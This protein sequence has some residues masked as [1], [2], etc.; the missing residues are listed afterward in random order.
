MLKQK[1]Y[2]DKYSK[3]VVQEIVTMLCKKTYEGSSGNN[4]G[5]NAGEAGQVAEGDE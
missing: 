5:I 1:G 2:T 3:G 4:T